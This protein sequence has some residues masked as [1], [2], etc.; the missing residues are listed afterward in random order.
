MTP[1]RWLFDLISGAH[2]A[3]LVMLAGFLAWLYWFP[4]MRG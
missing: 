2:P 1:L 4:P 3:E